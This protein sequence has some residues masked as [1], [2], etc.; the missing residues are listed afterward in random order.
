MTIF[1]NYFEKDGW[2]LQ[3]INEGAK[4]KTAE[5]VNNVL[6]SPIIYRDYISLSTSYNRQDYTE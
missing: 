5:F 6:L 2:N 1:E 3:K 4:N